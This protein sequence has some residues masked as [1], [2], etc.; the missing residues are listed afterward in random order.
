MILVELLF[1]A[2]L[3]ESR[4]LSF[5]NMGKE[6]SASRLASVSPVDS[7]MKTTRTIYE[8]LV[9]IFET[10]VIITRQMAIVTKTCIRHSM[11]LVS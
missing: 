6:L 11:I 10:S 5:D 7:I 2:H 9:L 3:P 4:E 1:K 8:R